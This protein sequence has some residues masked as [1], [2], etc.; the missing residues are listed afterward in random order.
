MHAECFRDIFAPG[1]GVSIAAAFGTYAAWCRVRHVWVSLA[2]LRRQLAKAGYTFHGETIL[3]VRLNTVL[4]PYGLNLSRASQYV[5]VQTGLLRTLRECGVGPAGMGNLYSEQGL[6]QWRA[7]LLEGPSVDEPELWG[8]LDEICRFNEIERRHQF[9]Y[10]MIFNERHFM[11]ENRWRLKGSPESAVYAGS[12]K[13]FADMV[14]RGRLDR[15]EDQ[16]R[17]EFRRSWRAPRF[18]LPADWCPIHLRVSE[19]DLL[20][21]VS[22]WYLGHAKQPPAVLREVLLKA[23]GGPPLHCKRV[24]AK[25]SDGKRRHEYRGLALRS[26]ETAADAARAEQFREESGLQI[27][28]ASLFGVT[29]T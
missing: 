3:G 13:V 6:E 20:A 18:D 22:D 1:S 24:V 14:K 10:Q 7:R 16:L 5:G 12:P 27:T 15:T 25:G 21:A 26:A 19:A 2:I 23:L 11:E 29:P 4:Q 8:C 17:D 9:T 28:L